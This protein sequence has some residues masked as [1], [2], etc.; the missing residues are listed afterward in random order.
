MES[1]KAS[2]AEPQTHIARSRGARR[3][4]RQRP[5][6]AGIQRGTA[7]WAQTMRSIQHGTA[8][9]E[10]TMRSNQPS[11]SSASSHHG[12][13]PPDCRSP[14]TTKSGKVRA[15]EAASTHR[16]EP[17]AHAQTSA[18]TP[19]QSRSVRTASDALQDARGAW[20]L[21]LAAVAPAAR[22]TSRAFVASGSSARV[23]AARPV[24]CDPS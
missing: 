4:L 19:W 24:T 11:T 22:R 3:H 14:A 6:R 12:I 16:K 9:R 10:Q 8:S 20:G 13:D 23:N 7:S 21:T 17:P 5:G 18:A 1:G 2:A 15:A